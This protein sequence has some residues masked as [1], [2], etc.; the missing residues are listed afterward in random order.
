[1]AQRAKNSPTMKET[2]VR[3]LGWED[4]LDEGSG[5]ALQY[6]YL[7]NPRDRGARWATVHKVIK[8]WT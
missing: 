4:F 5:N 2:P 8:S 3:S 7:E 1:M 6:S